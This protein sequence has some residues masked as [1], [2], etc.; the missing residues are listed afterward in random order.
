MSS[1]TEYLTVAAMY[2]L[3]AAATSQGMPTTRSDFAQLVQDRYKWKI[4][5][6]SIDKIIRQLDAWNLIIIIEDKYAGEMLRLFSA[7]SDAALNLVAKY[8]HQDLISK[9]ASGGQEWFLRVF[10]NQQFWDDLHN[11]PLP[12]R[13]AIQEDGQPE[14]SLADIPASD[15][16]VTRS[17]NKIEVELIEAD[18]RSLA[19]EIS[20]NNEAAVEIGEERELIAGELEAAETLIK[21]PSFRLSRLAALIIPALRFLAEK[22]AS[23]AIGEMAKRLIAA[24]LGLH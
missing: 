19:E 21:Q 7:K 12:K 5:D 24:I 3:R 8:G 22:F 18:V 13:G 6:R 11:D 1:P 4:D 16:V 9:A 23:G 20:H 15:R 17:D 2:A 10:Q 14:K